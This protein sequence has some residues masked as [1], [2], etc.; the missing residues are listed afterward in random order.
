MNRFASFLLGPELLWVVFY[1]ICGWLRAFNTPPSP[2]GNTLLE[3]ACTLGMFLA[4]A[5]TFVVFAV[6][7]ANRWVLMVRV[8]ISVGIGLNVCLVRLID[9]I[10]YGDSRNSGVLGFWVYGV[11]LGG[12]TLLPGLIATGILLRKTATND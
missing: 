4:T 5:L 8:V 1:V 3:R 7:G 2:T 9:G 11:L 10:N 6:P 12:L